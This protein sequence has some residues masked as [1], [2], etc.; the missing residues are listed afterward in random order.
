MHKRKFKLRKS[1]SPGALDV[2]YAGN[3]QKA[4]PV[5]IYHN[6]E[7]LH[8]SKKKFSHVVPQSSRNILV[9]VESTMRRANQTMNESDPAQK[10]YKR[11]V[12]GTRNYSLINPEPSRC[13][14]R[15]TSPDMSQA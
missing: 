15:N 11:H 9:G 8:F 12:L 14:L 2:G 3:T 13:L 1:P 4:N 6:L 5:K 7:K 10:K